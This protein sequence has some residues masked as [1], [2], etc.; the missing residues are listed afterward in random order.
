M[1]N[2]ANEQMQKLSRDPVFS[3]GNR[4][5]TL[6]AQDDE[7]FQLPKEPTPAIVIKDGEEMDEG[8]QKADAH[9]MGDGAAILDEE[10]SQQL[11]F[12]TM[13]M[14]LKRMLTKMET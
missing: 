7:V 8:F 9:Y 5:I 2:L 4:V 6:D 10:A 3:I 11:P 14:V 1:N 12:M 13:S